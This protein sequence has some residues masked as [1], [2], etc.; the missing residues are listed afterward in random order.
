MESV[1]RVQDINQKFQEHLN[2]NVSIDLLLYCMKN[3]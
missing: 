2:D 1:I 3:K